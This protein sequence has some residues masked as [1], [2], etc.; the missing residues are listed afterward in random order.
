MISDSDYFPSTHCTNERQEHNI[1]STLKEPRFSDLCDGPLS[2]GQ[3]TFETKIESLN[4]K[5][6]NANP[7]ITNASSRHHPPEDWYLVN[8][9]H[10]NVLDHGMMNDL[11][12]VG[13]A[14]ALPTL[15]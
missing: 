4:H 14:D 7:M 5:K 1:H 10:H 12:L 2:L 13:Q 6:L 8:S 3:L 11:P 9:N 15:M